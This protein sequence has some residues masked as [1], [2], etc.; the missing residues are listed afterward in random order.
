MSVISSLTTRLL[1]IPLARPWGETVR[2]I[3]VVVVEIVDSSGNRGEGFSW[4]PT[5]GARSVQ[6]LIDNDIRQFVLGAT[7]DPE[8]IWTSL[9][10]HLHEAGGG[11]ITTIAMAGV[12]LALWDLVA[13]RDGVAATRLWGTRRESV[14]TYGSGVNLHYTLDDLVA[15]VGRWVAA[16]H[17]AVKIKVGKPS[18][19][20]DVDRVAAVR[21][22]LGPERKLMVDA[23]QRWDLATAVTAAEALRDFDIAWLEEPLR[24]DNLA[25]HTVLARQCGIPI[26]LG[27]NLHTIY[28]FRDFLDAGA[29]AVIQPNV[30]RVGG[31]TPF[32]AIAQLAAER[33]VPLYPHLLPDLSGQLALC[34]DQETLVEDVEDAGFAHLGALSGPSPVVIQSTRLSESD[35]VGLGLTF[36]SDL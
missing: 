36:R 6:A 32:R 27:E 21:A 2:E 1:T 15:Q 3:H 25:D 24:A 29:A 10:E 20:E 8:L 12:D 14:G 17:T 19:A 33:N 5:I 4:T 16:G 34:L 22:V 18:I 23:N 7:A 26:A 30:V 9:W 11:G 31:I 35:H 13:R 28:R